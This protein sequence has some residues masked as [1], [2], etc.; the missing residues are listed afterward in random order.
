MTRY[1]SVLAALG[2]CLAVPAA[3]AGAARTTTDAATG[4]KT[5][6]LPD[7][8]TAKLGPDGLGWRTD[9]NGLRG[10]PFT[11]M[12]PQGQG[13]LGGRFGPSDLEIQRRLALPQRGRFAPGR[14]I[15]S[16]PGAAPATGFAATKGAR[17][18]DARVDETLRTV[19][20]R[21]MRAVSA[22]SSLFVVDVAGD[23]PVRAARKLRATPGVAY[24]EPDWIVSSM[25]TEPRPIPQTALRPPKVQALAPKPQALPANFG[26]QSSLQSWLNATGV[27]AIGAY[28]DIARRF[29]QLPGQGTIVTNV[30]IGDLT[31]QAM[32]DAGDLYVASFG[33]TTRVIAGQR[34]LD[35]P[36]MPLIPTYTVD[37]TGAIDPLG[38]VEFVDPFLGEVLL[39]FS[40]MAPLP[41]DRQRPE[42]QGAGATDLLGIAPGAQYRLVVPKEPTI[43]NI[44]TAMLAAAQQ[45]PRPDVISAS[46]G[47]G[48]DSVGFPGRY[49]EDDPIAQSV[50]STIVHRYGVVVSIAANDGTRLFTPA[51]VGPDG[52]STP[53]DLLPPG[54]QPTS[55]ADDALS[56]TPTLIADSGAIAVGGVTLDDIFSAP[57]Q[58]GGTLAG[59]GQFPTT[60]FNGGGGFS[61]GF[62]TRVN[63]SA[64][65]D[66]IPSFVHSC[67]AGFGCAPNDVIP[68]LSGGT[69]ASAPMTAAAAAVAIQVARL[70][71][72]RADPLQV[73]DL[74]VRTARPTTDAPQSDRSLHVGPQLDVTAAVESLL[75]TDKRVSGSIVRVSVAHRQ[76]F[77]DLGET[78]I[79][80][81]DPSAIDLLGP[82]LDFFGL[83]FSL[84]QNAVA[85][86]TI[87][88]DV[89][90]VPRD[91]AT[92]F[93]LRVGSMVLTSSQPSF[94]LLPEEI[95]SAAGMTLVADSNR[96]VAVTLEARRSGRVIDSRSLSL[97]F[98]PTD[99]TYA[100]ALAP[101]VNPVV[102]AGRGVVVHYD[103]RNVR[104][105][106]NP[107][108]VVSSVNHFSPVMA[109]FFRA[110]T[111]IP[112]KKLV[113]D[114]SVPASA[115]AGGS[116]LY[117]IGTITDPDSF[118]FGEFAIVRVGPDGA[119]RPEAPTL[120][121]GAGA[122]GHSLAIARAAPRFQLRWD[123][124]SVAGADGAIM[125]IS[126]PAPTLF[127][128]LNTF[129]NHNG[130][131]RDDNGVE[132]TSTFF[133][134]L[135]GTSGT[136]DFDAVQ[137]QLPSSLFYN[138]RIFA[139]RR[140]KPIGQASAS[141]ALEFDDGLAPGGAVLSNFDIT[142]ASSTVAL[143]SF[144]VSGNPVDSSL[145]TY[146]PAT[147]TYGAAFADDPSG[148]TLYSVIG[149]DSKLH[150]AAVLRFPFFFDAP[151][152]VQVYD[153]ATGTRRS[154]VSVDLATQYFLVNGRVDSRKHRAA[155]LAYSST[156][157]TDQVIP[158]DLSTGALG[159]SFNADL[160]LDFGGVF[161]SIDVDSAS[162]R[163][164]LGQAFFGDI[165]IGG[166]FGFMGEVDLDD[167]TVLPV[168]TAIHCLTAF[169]ADQ[170]GRNVHALLGPVFS[171]PR[172]IPP[173][174]LQEVAQRDLT[175]AAPEADLGGNG[176]VFAASDPKNGL[177]VV[178][179]L[180]GSDYLV[181]NVAMSAVGVYDTG[182]GRQI[183][184][185]QRFN[186]ANEVFFSSLLFIGERGIQLDPSTRTAWT[187]GPGGAQVQ[188][189][190]Y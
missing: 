104:A 130:D 67:D 145:T 121:D 119:P 28:A 17:T 26:L 78:F 106:N 54:A 35:I 63:I 127:G 79:E 76:A 128:A 98:G 95:L 75:G 132:S 30:S 142:S 53:T 120:D 179:F 60:R 136:V 101:S 125:E 27:N 58:S 19:G 131:R 83:L 56:T 100:E 72:Q 182:S 178:G 24:A 49:L 45:S 88:A 168:S 172:L 85:P 37:S 12:R 180:A 31:D 21:S 66:N 149:S 174:R 69:S 33:P 163:A 167:G 153:T 73:R 177:L 139:T 108:L 41:H 34:Y 18:G 186:F 38:T 44:L 91:E 154:S 138:V 126:A 176:P 62:G 140:G 94:R 171:F 184:L 50:V 46:L 170:R 115:F 183:S 152:E 47:F 161:N 39:D 102:T 10:A 173:G 57:P 23:D 114:V 144:D 71:R 59:L 185:S 25:A 157:F 20:A 2:A 96:T 109:P 8:S 134:P 61:S 189:F 14:V 80:A 42:A 32:A 1:R 187:F 156:D 4:A 165:C 48:T 86:I 160:G 89:T 175:L 15:V 84:G 148:Q 150:A 105:L 68:V 155:I 7:G 22:G 52:G 158:V 129:T 40:V 146:S 92:S 164:I 99:G 123:V 151:Q 116:G 51:A 16:V 81:T 55:V 110:E 5:F 188:Q 77:Q 169:A 11:V 135:P 29:G 9:R 43:S 74:L 141:S 181:N 122:F 107:A 159:Q 13:G 87:A 147:G 143:V 6:T 97:T 190:S 118:V 166:H 111:T 103:L 36:S 65:S 124:S 82:T 117:G 137:L 113:G 70:T 90:G 93:A 133:Q 112:L 64:P 3:F 162:G